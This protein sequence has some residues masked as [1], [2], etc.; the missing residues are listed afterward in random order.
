MQSVMI[1]T[2]SQRCGRNRRIIRIPTPNFGSAILRKAHAS[3]KMTQKAAVGTVSGKLVE[4][5]CLVELSAFWKTA[6][7][8]MSSAYWT[9][10]SASCIRVCNTWC[11]RS[12]GFTQEM[13]MTTSSQPATSFCR[14]SREKI[15]MLKR[16]VDIAVKGHVA[17]EAWYALRIRAS[18]P[19]IVDSG[20]QNL[21]NTREWFGKG[22]KGKSS[23]MVGR[24]PKR[25]KRQKE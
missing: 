17:A 2:L 18:W 7:L 10:Q 6:A 3:V 20:S 25:L 14:R 13:E 22:G 4:V 1:E 23:E 21:P 15:L 16:V 5:I 8:I 9:K 24:P 19:A 12:G 11:S